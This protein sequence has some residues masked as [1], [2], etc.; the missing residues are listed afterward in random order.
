MPSRQILVSAEQFTYVGAELACS[1]RPGAGRPTSPRRCGLSWGRVLEV[2]AGFGATAQALCRG[3]TYRWVCLEPDVRLASAIE[4]ARA[5]G[6]LPP[7]CEVVVGT[8]EGAA[9][10]RFDT[11]L[12]ID[13]LE[14]I[15][16]DRAELARAARH[17]APGGHLVVLS[18]A[19]PWL[20]SPV[21]SGDRPLSPVHCVHAPS[22]SARWPGA[23]PAALPGLDRRRLFSGQSLAP[24]SAAA[25]IRS[26][27]ALGLADDSCLEVAGS[28]DRIPS[29]P[30]APGSVE[31]RLNSR[32]RCK[33]TIAHNRA[34]V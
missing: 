10:G 2:G 33:L 34:A 7:W 5:E 14:H 25:D 13:V 6:M 32:C 18:P 31:G 1:R 8:L 26:N 11:I 17:L 27:Q 21:R 22:R 12:Y 28:S 15:E 23:G 24:Q 4:A 29:G 3:D 9:L 16:D 19:H 30:Y 20:F